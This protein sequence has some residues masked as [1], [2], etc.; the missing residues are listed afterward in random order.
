[1]TFIILSKDMYETSKNEIES[2]I[3]DV[4]IFINDADDVKYGE[5]EIMIAEKWTRGKG[6]GKEAVCTMLRYGIENL[7]LN[8]FIA[9]IGIQNNT[10]MAAVNVYHTSV[11]TDNL[12]RH[13]ILQWINNA[14]D[15]NYIK[16]ED[17]CTGAAYCQF[18]E[19]MFPG[20]MQLKKVKF[21]AKLEHENIQNFKILQNSFRAVHIDKIVPVEK[22]VKGKF[23]DNFEFVQWFKK[24]FDANYTPHDY[25][26]VAAREGQP[27]GPGVSKGGTHTSGT[28]GLPR[29]ALP[30]PAIRQTQHQNPVS[31]GS[32]NPPIQRVPLTSTNQPRQVPNTMKVP[33][34]KISPSTH[35]QAPAAAPVDH[36]LNGETARLQAEL[37]IYHQQTEQFRQQIE[38]LEKERDFYYQK[39]R[40]VELICQEPDCENLPQIQK[41]LEVLYATEEGFASPEEN[42]NGQ[43]IGG[44]VIQG[45]GDEEEY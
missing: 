17:L 9:K 1:C 38:G 45:G 40:D 27:L 20:S 12:S 21:N 34:Q 13:D 18:M 24:F 31:H 43:D 6:L 41:V 22:L 25:D 8:R 10:W 16:V 32:V 19:M 30:Q 28:S 23:Q 42:G 7:H 5:I 3:G 37:E 33:Q 36:Q 15:A 2:M 29:A 35:R 4:N 14:L 26:P 39:L 44:A 11:T